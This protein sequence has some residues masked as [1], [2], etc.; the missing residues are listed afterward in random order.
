MR[1]LY[2]PPINKLGNISF[3]RL[4]IKY[5][6]DYVFTEMVRGEKILEQDEFQIQKLKV[7]KDMQNLTIV[8]IICE[9]ILN[10][11]K[12]V[13]KV[14]Q[15]NPFT[16]EINYNMGC[17][18][19][20]LVKSEMGAGIV[21]NPKK[22][23]QVAEILQNA[24]QKYNVKASIKIRLGI[25]R[26]NITI[27]KNVEKIK[28]AGIKKIYIHARTIDDTYNKHA[29]YSEIAKVKELFKDLE[30]IANGD[31]LDSAS[32]NNILE[33]NCDGVLIGRAA[34]QNPIIFKKI[35]EGRFEKNKSGDFINSK[36]E[37]ILDYL[38]FAK[39]DKISISHI[40]AN[41]AYMTKG[42]IGVNEIRAK[43]NN[44]SDI[45][46]IIEFFRSIN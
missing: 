28:K 5:G 32:Y 12:T 27:Y 35:K 31:V 46:E 11:E 8:Q 43:I 18:Q 3:R 34:L 29:T 24:C 33:T 21:G 40:K 23:E 14:I 7:S 1:T 6:A 30:I 9:D 38:N 2:F 15:L 42:L 36:K 39:E 41:L 45:E 37:I 26:D 10:I 4:C 44:I 16:F 25:T 17:P 19:S 22:V 20:S 13:D